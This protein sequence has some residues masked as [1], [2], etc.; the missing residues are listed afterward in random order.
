MKTEK[1]I[2][3]AFLLN[4]AFSVFELFGGLFTGS[5]AILSDSIHDLGDAFSI[6]LSWLLEKKSA[7]GPDENYSYGYSRFS[8]LGGFLTSAV[9]IVGSVTVIVASVRRIFHPVPVNYSGMLIFAV[10]GVAVNFLAALFTR[11]GDSINQKAVNLHMLEDVLGWCVVLVGSLVMKFTDLRLIDP[12]MSVAVSVFILVGA[13]R[14]LREVVELFLMKT[15]DGVPFEGIRSAAQSVE[16]V[17][18][19]HHVHVW[20]MDGSLSCAELHVVT[21]GDPVRVKRELREKLAEIGIGHVTLELERS[22]ERCGQTACPGLHGERNE[23]PHH[24]H[25]HSH[26]AGT[27]ASGECP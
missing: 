23:H 1:N 20:S 6:G 12:L 19:I 16:G 17:E 26:A 14:E 3:V 21:D 24:H 8:V 15:P 10:F 9:L 22:S 27:A 2:L 5:V 18:E 7:R 25:H 4:L 13:L 11:E